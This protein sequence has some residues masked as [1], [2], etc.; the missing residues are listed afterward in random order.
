MKVTKVVLV[1]LLIVGLL[2]AV[3]FAGGGKGGIKPMGDP[4]NGF[5]VED[6]EIVA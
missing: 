2:T 6:L 3:V 1:A 5:N 4:P